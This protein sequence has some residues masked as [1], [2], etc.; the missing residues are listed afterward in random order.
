MSI[1]KFKTFMDC[2]F[3]VGVIFLSEGIAHPT[4]KLFCELIQQARK[5]ETITFSEQ[6]CPVGA[7]VLGRDAPRPDE[8][9]F[10]SGRYRNKESAVR[11]AEALPRLE[12]RYRSVQIF[13]LIE[14]IPDFDILLLFLSPEKAM[15]LVQ[16]FSYHDGQPLTFI[17]GGTAS[18]CGDCTAAPAN[19]GRIGVSLGCKGSR[20]HSKYGENELIVA[21]PFNLCKEIC[22]G[23]LAI[24]GTFD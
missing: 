6:G 16:A 7:Y 1:A 22:E 5:G 18:I 8:Y 19:T 4:E 10:N 9:Y 21:V 23:L 2:G 24:P 13:P 14:K 15:R 17:T 3:P 12:A 20:K 11:A